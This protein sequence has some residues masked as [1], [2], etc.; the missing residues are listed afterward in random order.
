MSRIDKMAKIWDLILER[1]RTMKNK[2]NN[3]KQLVKMF[4]K[5]QADGL[6]T[7]KTRKGKDG[8][9]I[10]EWVSLMHTQ[11]TADEVQEPEEQ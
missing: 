7:Y 3:R 6:I 10:Y 2:S 8:A 9:I 4:D 1:V 11:P 5:A